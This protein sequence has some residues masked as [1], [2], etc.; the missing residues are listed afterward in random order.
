MIS[1]KSAKFSKKN[2]VKLVGS[3]LGEKIMSSPPT[4]TSP[5][6]FGAGTAIDCLF[7]CLV[8]RITNHFPN[9]YE[10]TRKD[11]MLK[12][13]KRYR[14]ELEKEGSPFAEKDENGKYVYLG[15]FLFSVFSYRSGCVG[16]VI[17]NQ[18]NSENFV[19]STET[20]K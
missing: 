16:L 2:D 17:L 8:C 20:K 1:L 15:T 7:D 4:P 5:R 9:H 13:V 19:D 12:N 6:F 3:T 11:L 10:L 18:S 14:K